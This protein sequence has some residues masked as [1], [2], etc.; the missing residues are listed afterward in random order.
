MRLPTTSGDPGFFALRDA[1]ATLP[2]VEAVSS[3]DLPIGLLAGY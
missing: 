1:I 3:G 2:G